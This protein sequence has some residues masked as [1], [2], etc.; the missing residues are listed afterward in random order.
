MMTNRPK[1]EPMTFQFQ[2]EKSEDI[3]GYWVY[4]ASAI[5]LEELRE[6][7][8]DHFCPVSRRPV[9]VLKTGGNHYK[10]LITEEGVVLWDVD[11]ATWVDEVD[12]RQCTIRGTTWHHIG[13]DFDE[14]WTLI[15]RWED[16]VIEFGVRIM[17][18][19]FGETSLENSKPLHLFQGDLGFKA[20]LP[21]YEP[22]DSNSKPTRV[23]QGL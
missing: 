15:F 22:P 20:S 18:Y 16:T 21:I 4:P 14:S 2:G 6:I 7:L 1:V 11:V 3:K 12:T 8:D 9:P 5:S 19:E 13:L 10:E 23:F 17:Q